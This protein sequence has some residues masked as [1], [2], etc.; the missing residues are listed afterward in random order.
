MFR[1]IALALAT[2]FATDFATAAPL[3][4]THSHEMDSAPSAQD[5]FIDCITQVSVNF[6]NE[7]DDVRRDYIDKV[8]AWD[9][10]L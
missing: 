1:A 9:D 8:L 2:T 3:Q 5:Q 7:L 10:M 6:I 4:A